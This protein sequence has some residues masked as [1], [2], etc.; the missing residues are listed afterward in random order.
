M[1]TIFHN[2]RHCDD[3]G[4]HGMLKRGGMV[5]QLFM[6]ICDLPDWLFEGT[7]PSCGGDPESLPKRSR[8]PDPPGSGGKQGID[9]RGLLDHHDKCIQEVAYRMGIDLPM[10][11]YWDGKAKPHGRLVS[12]EEQFANALA[13]LGITPEDFE[14]AVLSQ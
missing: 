5:E 3:R 6:M 8:P 1:T 11:D 4:T 9:I 12:S 2:C 14:Q 13:N 7:C 10:H